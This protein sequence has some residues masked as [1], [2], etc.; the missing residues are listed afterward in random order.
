MRIKPTFH[1]VKAVRLSVFLG[2]LTFSLVSSSTLPA[3]SQ[4]SRPDLINW[5]NGPAKADLV[6]NAEIEVPAGFSLATGGDA[7]TLLKLMNNPAPASLAGVLAPASRSYVIIFEYSPIGYVK[8]ATTRKINPETVLKHIRSGVSHETI[9]SSISS[10][11]WQMEPQFDRQQNLVEW[12]ILAQTASSKTVNHVV[13][14]L[15]R[16]GML[17]AIAVQNVGAR[18]TIPLK[19]VVSKIAFKPGYAYEDYQEGDKLSERNIAELI[20]GESSPELQTAASDNLTYAIGGG[21]L[22]LLGAGILVVRRKKSSATS[23]V[24]KPAFHANGSK[25]NGNGS[26]HKPLPAKLSSTNRIN[27]TNGQPKKVRRQMFDYQRYYTDLMS[28]VSDRAEAQAAPAG[29][30]AR[31]VA[32]RRIN[33]TD[34]RTPT[35]ELHPNNVAANLSLIEGQKRLIEEQQRLI[36][37]QAKLIEEKSRVIHEQSQ[38]LEKQSELFGNHV[39]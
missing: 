28:Q 39:F 32:D 23:M 9:T 8:N 31:T 19:E 38:V 35:L 37:E 14:L 25:L 3:F 12:A 36:R 26:N 2:F 1:D 24:A 20:A 7:V 30:R 11:D 18:D 21:V 29:S 4:T 6:G 27:G 15:G 16:E 33:G 13:R 10:V 34:L 22:V 17:D 5:I